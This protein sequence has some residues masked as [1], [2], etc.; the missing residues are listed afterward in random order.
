MLGCVGVSEKE[1]VNFA[2]KKSTIQIT[3]EGRTESHE[4]QFFV[5]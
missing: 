2:A 4:E 5:K 1:A 3:Y